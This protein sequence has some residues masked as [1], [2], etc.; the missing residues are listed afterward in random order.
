[1]QSFT[2]TFVLMHPF[3]W[4]IT[5]V[6]I[7]TLKAAS[8]AIPYFH[9]IVLAVFNA[10]S[11]GIVN[12]RT[13]NV[14]DPVRQTYTCACVCVICHVVFYLWRISAREPSIRVE[15]I[16]TITCMFVGTG[17]HIPAGVL[18]VRTSKVSWGYHQ[19][20]KITDEEDHNGSYGVLHLVSLGWTGI[21][22]IC[23][24]LK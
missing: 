1:M 7:A 10:S 13:W 21:W 6:A 8:K 22:I 19:Q 4:C 17:P 16:I 11:P 5:I 20:M 2:L 18:V 23:E 24:L 14:C 12:F 15:A 9:T 3:L